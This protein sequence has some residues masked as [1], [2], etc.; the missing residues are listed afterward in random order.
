MNSS[1][2]I[3]VPLADGFE[4]I[5]AVTI[6]DVLRRAEL[7]VTVAGLTAGPIRGAHDVTIETDCALDAVDPARVSMLVLPGGMPGTTHLVEDERIL[8]LVRDL[9][10]GGRKVA[11][12]CAAPLVLAEA[13]VLGAGP[14]TS[15]P[16]VR[17]RLG[18]ARVVDSPRVVR[19]G[20]I[21]TSQGPGT[22]LE[23]ALAIVADLRGEDRARELGAA[24]L[25]TQPA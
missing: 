8:G 6:I 2:T 21:L 15:H 11:A 20:K 19:A 4:E 1:D 18:A 25:A 12:I 24:M 9:I 3:L 5:E 17:D 22:A 7:S 13:G 23:F 10:A 16:S 14:V